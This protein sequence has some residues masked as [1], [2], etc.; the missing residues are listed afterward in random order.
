MKKNDLCKLIFLSL[1]CM[2]VC[3]YGFINLPVLRE[4]VNSSDITYQSWKKNASEIE[5]QLKERMA[6][7]QDL[8][9]LY[10]VSLRVLGKNMVGNFEFIKDERG[11]VQMVQNLPENDLFEQ[12]VIALHNRLEQEGTH[13]I[14]LEAPNKV[15][16]F[17]LSEQLYF[18]GQSLDERVHT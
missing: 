13:L 6:G 8:V 10:G 5:T 17:Q 16:G 11:I 7:R 12:S 9:D 4:V 15:D 3:G 14:Y 18:F 2:L 1:M